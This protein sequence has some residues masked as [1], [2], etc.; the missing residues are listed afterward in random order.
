MPVSVKVTV[1]VCHCV[2]G[3]GLFN[4]QIGFRTHSL[5][6]SVNLMVTVMEMQMETV[7]V[8]GPFTTIIKFAD[9]C[10]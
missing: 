8:N 3:D 7:R 6:V 9:K 5:S 4:G 2:N 1:K 10:L